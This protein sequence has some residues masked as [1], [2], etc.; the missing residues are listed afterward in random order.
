[1][2]KDHM[3]EILSGEKKLIPRSTVNFVQVNKYDE[4]SVKTLYTK[5]L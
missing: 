3:K 2:T 5:M 1:M 4:I